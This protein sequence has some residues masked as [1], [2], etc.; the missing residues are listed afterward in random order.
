MR[1]DIPDFQS[2]SA[3]DQALLGEEGTHRLLAAGRAWDLAPVLRAGGAVIFPHT[4]IAACGHQVAAAVHACLDSGARRVL[5]I[6]V[7]HALTQE[8]EEARVRVANGED[9]AREPTWGIQ[10]PGLHGREEWRAEFSLSHFLFLW[11]H[12]TARRGISGPELVVRYPSLAGGRPDLLPGIAELQEIAQEAV[13]V[14][15][16]DPFHHGIGYGDLPD[17]ALAPTEGGLEL[18]RQ[19]IE[20]GLALLQGGEYWNYNRHCVQAKSDGRDVGQVLRCLRGPQKGRI[21]D[22][23]ADDM[24]AAYDKP[25]PTWVAGALIALL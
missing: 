22:L 16:M 21:L 9:P 18:A 23:I 6:G 5:A 4:S 2:R 10:G 3:Q 24:S 19:S 11:K 1:R 12:E 20:E 13:V 15:T 17:E 14:A 8:L 7:L 25:A